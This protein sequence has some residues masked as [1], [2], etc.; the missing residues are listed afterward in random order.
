MF[1]LGLQ[2]YYPKICPCILAFLKDNLAFVFHSDIKFLDVFSKQILH[3]VTLGIREFE[4]NSGLKWPF[5][6]LSGSSVR[7]KI[8]TAWSALYFHQVE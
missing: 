6:A 8:H 5:L 7:S 3:S 2:L 1:L 4:A